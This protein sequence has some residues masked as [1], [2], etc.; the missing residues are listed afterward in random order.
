MGFH[1]CLES[2]VHPEGE[3]ESTLPLQINAVKVKHLLIRGNM[4]DDRTC[5]LLNQG[6]V[7]L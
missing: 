2:F 7:V 3:R 1:P 5:C 6:N 4:I